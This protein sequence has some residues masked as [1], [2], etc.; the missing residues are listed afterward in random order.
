MLIRFFRTS[1]PSAFFIIPVFALLWWIPFFF[2][3]QEYFTATP[4]HTMPL[5]EWISLAINKL[6][7]VAQMILSWLL[8]SFQ[9]LYLNQLIVKH[10]L[11]PRLSFLPALIFITLSVMFPELMRIQPS[12]FVNLIL[13][14]LLD[15]IFLLYKNPEPSGK[16][17]DCSF[18]VGL[19]TLIDISS[20]V[21]YF[22]FLVALIMLQP[23]HWRS[24]VISLIGFMLPYYFISVYFF[25]MDSLGDF[26]KKKVPDAFSLVHF[27]SM[28]YSVV[29][30]A[31]LSLVFLLMLF[32]I[33]SVSKHFYKNIIRTRKYFQLIFFLLLTSALSLFIGKN[34]LPASICILLIPLSVLFAYYFLQVKKK[35]LAEFLFTVLIAL[36]IFNRFN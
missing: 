19:A 32:S 8:I 22:F 7:L 1:H 15:K 2:Q 6:P 30:I 27:S 5:Y 13:L 26:W 34:M 18:L 10:E 3:Q 21:F 4:P 36:I 35:A 16:I 9:A 23:F 12:L 11:F 25:W 17:F 20:V 31:L 14:F 24:W 28:N 29:R 33:R